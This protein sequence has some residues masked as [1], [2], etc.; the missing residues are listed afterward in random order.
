MENNK[1]ETTITPVHNTT[2]P[3]TRMVAGPMDFTPG[4]ML[5]TN[6]DEFYINF[7]SPMSRGTR[8][9]QASMY[10]VYD[11][12]LQMLCDNPSNYYKEP[13]YTKY[14]SRFP[15]IWDK[16]IALQGKIGEYV[17]MARKNGDKWY[18]GGMT[19]WEARSFSVPLTF[20]DGKKYKVE[21]LKDGINADKH[22][23]DYQLIT[24]EINSG[25]VLTVDMAAGGG[26]TAILTEI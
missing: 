14:I 17:V 18:I 2:L 24:K 3:F 5:N 1:W 13:V 19:N 4:A 11:S 6:K 23:A 21:I 22:A 15:T 9:H 20:L 8:A 16:T 12:P 26:Y 7:K 10:V 25:E